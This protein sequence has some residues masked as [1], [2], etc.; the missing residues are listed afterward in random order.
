M[1]NP[2]RPQRALPPDSLLARLRPR[3]HKPIN[4]Q[5]MHPLQKHPRPKTHRPLPRKLLNATNLS[6]TDEDDD[7]RLPH[8]EEETRA[9]PT[10]LP[11]PA[12]P[13]AQALAQSQVGEYRGEIGEY[14]RERE[15]EFQVESG[16]LRHHKMLTAKMRCYL[17]R[18]IF[19]LYRK[20][21][22]LRTTLHLA[23]HYMDSF[24]AQRHL[25]RDQLETVA[26]AQTCLFVAMKY[27]EIYPP[28]LSEWVDRR[29][30]EEIVKLEAEVLAVLDFQLAQPT[31]Q[32][33]LEME[34]E[35]RG[36][37]TKCDLEEEESNQTLLLLDLCLFDL[38]MR[39]Y[40]Y[41]D[42]A[43]AISKL[44]RGEEG[45][46]PLSLG[47]KWMIERNQETVR[48]LIDQKYRRVLLKVD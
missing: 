14:L 25:F 44:G 34:M 12:G 47:V 16:Y 13:P 21:G 17:V 29:Y 19:K 32:S 39:Q 31:L 40:R 33:F 42:L 37:S 10:P 22:L 26:V 28:E 20:F 36:E 11:P 38:T 48:W 45:D 30:R 3:P 24:F 9:P 1:D 43:H 2:A 46:D 4:S 18:H 15:E 6:T 5:N 23:V 8:S 7:K 35:E 41:S 27:E